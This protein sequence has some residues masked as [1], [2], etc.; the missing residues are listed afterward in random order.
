L[1]RTLNEVLY[2]LEMLL[3]SLERGNMVNHKGT[4]LLETERL[5]LRGLKM[6]DAPNVFNNWASDK[7]VAKFMRWDA[8]AD[9]EV[10]REWMKVCEESNKTHYDWGIV[11]KESNEPIGSIGTFLNAEEPNRYEIGYAIGKKYWGY[12]YAT[13]AL[14]CVID[15]LSNSVGIQ[16]FICSH[17]KDNPASGAVMR[18]VG[19]VYIKDGSY[20]SFDGS[21]K[22]DSR[23][24]YLDICDQ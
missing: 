13:E 14:K 24:Y 18:R 11:L 19:F 22:F 3:V 20:R 2:E 5:I 7:D 12:R 15:F 23:V 9:I 6:E 17:A 1:E 8:H 4:V 16:H 10:T 21:R